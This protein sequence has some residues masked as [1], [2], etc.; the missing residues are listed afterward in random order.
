MLVCLTPEIARRR[1]GRDRSLVDVQAD[2]A[3]RTLHGPASRCGSSLHQVLYDL[4]SVTLASRERWS[5]H[6]DYRSASPESH[7][8]RFSQID[9]MK[10]VRY[11]PGQPQSP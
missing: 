3:Y 9:A 4:R 1:R 10:G 2:V 6:D 8:H 5:N 7:D 11:V